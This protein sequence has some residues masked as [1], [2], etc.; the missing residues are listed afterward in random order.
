MKQTTFKTP[1]GTEL[2]ML[3]LRG[4]PYLQVAHRLVWFREEHED[5]GIETEFLTTSDSEQRAICSARIKDASGRI[6]ATATKQEQARDFPDFIEKAETGAIGRALALCGYGTQFAP[7]LDE[8]ER[9]VDS[10][11]TPAKPGKVATAI[12]KQKQPEVAPEAKDRQFEAHGAATPKQKKFVADLAVQKLG[13]DPNDSKSIL[14][15]LNTEFKAMK[16][17][18]TS[19]DDLTVNKAKQIIDALIV[20]PDFTLPYDENKE[21]EV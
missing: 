17:S 9:I 6:I 13:A 7:E 8:G 4:K 5:W 21:P 11:T 2:P 12:D 19:S 16:L 15:S 14:E 20:K 1:K 10:P 3:D 18:L